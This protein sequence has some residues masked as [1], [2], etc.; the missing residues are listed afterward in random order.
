M[1]KN[2]LMPTAL[3]ALAVIACAMPTTTPAKTPKSQ[4]LPLTCISLEKPMTTDE[5]TIQENTQAKISNYFVG[6]GNIWEREQ[7]DAQ[8]VI[9]PRMSATL[10]ISELNSEQTRHEEVFVGS[11]ISLG[12]DRYCVV[13]VDEGNSTPGTLT[14]RKFP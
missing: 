10:A 3:V 8:G 9:A 7:P 5:I 12:S 13:N 2:Q 11:L 1:V 4:I 6:V 14:M